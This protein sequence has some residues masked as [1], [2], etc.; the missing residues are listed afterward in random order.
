[1]TFPR[2]YLTSFGPKDTPHLFTDILV[3]GAGIAGVRAA[4]EVPPDQRVLLVTKGRLDQSNSAWAQGGIA[5][6]MAPEDTFE[7]HI[8]DT[9]AAGGLCDRGVVEHVVREA[10][11]QIHDLIR[12]GTQFDLE[13]G[14]LALAREGGHSH[15][16]VVHALGDATGA[17]VMRALIEAAR[18][19]PNISLWDRRFT[20]DL[21]THDG[22]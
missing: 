9:L 8:E 4:L 18:R 14:Q 5:G 21:L 15:R 20:I 1:M 22:R 10:P 16:R 17:E 3:I 6:V 2:R 7:N 19:Q 11:K 12:F 13:G